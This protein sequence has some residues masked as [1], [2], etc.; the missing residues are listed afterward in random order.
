[1]K[2]D[3]SMPGSPQK[4]ICRPSRLRHRKHSLSCEV[5]RQAPFKHWCQAVVLLRGRVIATWR[6]KLERARL[7]L[8]CIPFHRLGRGEQASITTAAE[9]LTEFL[10]AKE[11]GLIVQ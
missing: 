1:M 11:L 2:R 9:Q 7:R 4:T 5:A 6:A 3:E 10:G 8:T